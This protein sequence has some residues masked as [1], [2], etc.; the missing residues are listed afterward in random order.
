MQ[1]I[2]SKT[3]SFIGYVD[4]IRLAKNAEYASTMELDYAVW[5]AS[6]YL[7]ENK[8]NKLSALIKDS[9]KIFTKYNPNITRIGEKANEMN[10]I[11]KDLEFKKADYSRVNAYLS[12]IPKIYLH[13]Q[14]KV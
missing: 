5:N 9:K 11:L 6:E 2:G 10:A 4:D 14:K 12:L 13:I 3:K 7:K 1:Y 8:N